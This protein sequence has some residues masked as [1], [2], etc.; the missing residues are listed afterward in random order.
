M[1]LAQRHQ[2][3]RQGQGD[4]AFGLGTRRCLHRRATSPDV[5]IC[6]CARGG[7]GGGGRA[8]AERGRRGGLMRCA[9]NGATS[10]ATLESGC[11]TRGGAPIEISMPA[12]ARS[13]TALAFIAASDSLPR[14][15]A[16]LI[17]DR[18]QIYGRVTVIAGAAKG[19]HMEGLAYRRSPCSTAH[20]IWGASC[21]FILPAAWTH[22]I[23]Q[24]GPRESATM[25]H[26]TK[27][28]DPLRS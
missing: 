10:P 27:Q 18:E 24:P 3:R 19:S 22:P 11:R 20:G 12:G 16:T 25:R 8:G 23:C 26:Q 21:L 13:T 9:S 4:N 14:A 5:R 15:S 28:G 2:D 7:G 1:Y 6:I 17:P